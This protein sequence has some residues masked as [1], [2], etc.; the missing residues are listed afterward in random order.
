MA[1][2]M[3]LPGNNRHRLFACTVD[4]GND[5]VQKQNL[6]LHTGKPRI[7]VCDSSFD[8]DSISFV[9]IKKH[10]VDGNF[11]QVQFTPVAFL[12]FI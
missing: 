11:C 5:H 7:V 12:P 4:I 3:F 1:G 8:Y 2:R 6:G 10:S 9:I